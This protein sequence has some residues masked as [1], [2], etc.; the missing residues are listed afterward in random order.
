[1]GILL[2]LGYVVLL[3]LTIWQ[4]RQISS[5]RQQLSTHILHDQLT[6][7][8]HRR[9]LIKLAEQEINR[10]QRKNSTVSALLVDLDDCSKINHQY[11][12]LAGDLALQHVA[13]AAIESIRDFDLAGRF[14]GEEIILILPDTDQK[15]AEVV[16]ERLRE[17]VKQTTVELPDRFALDVTIT[18]G[19]ACTHNETETLEDL[20]LTA[21]T[22]LRQ[23]MLEGND[24]IH[25]YRPDEGVSGST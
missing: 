18:I 13:K 4:S 19:L 7:L 20:L 14:S 21:D 8:Y 15:G 17:K 1:M 10:A 9:Q 16:A 11:G 12:H 2:L 23:A 3:A 24:R 22:A 6:G 25:C 5:L